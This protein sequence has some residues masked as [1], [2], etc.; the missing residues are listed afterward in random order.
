MFKDSRVEDKASGFE[1]IILASSREF[2][3]FV[4]QLLGFEANY[5]TYLFKVIEFGDT[6]LMNLSGNIDLDTDNRTL[7]F[8]L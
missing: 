3:I 6:I 2:H 8:D 7:L 1:F 4:I 5:V